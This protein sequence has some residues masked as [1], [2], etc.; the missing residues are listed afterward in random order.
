MTL[1]LDTHVVLW[2][3]LEP[4]RLKPKAQDA[5]VD[6][7]ND[8]VVSAVTAWEIA[9]KH[10]VGKLRLPGEPDTWLPEQVARAGLAW[11]PVTHGEALDVAT[12]PWHHRDPFDRLLISQAKQGRTLVTHDEQLQAYGVSVLWA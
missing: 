6:P 5:I 12:L 4:D 1:L 9:I 2:C 7:T 10:G 11:I 3:L 8:V